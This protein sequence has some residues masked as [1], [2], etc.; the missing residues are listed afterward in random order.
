[1]ENKKSEVSYD[2]ENLID[3]ASQILLKV[4]YSRKEAELTARVLVEANLRGV[5][6]HGIARLKRYVDDVINKTTI[7]KTKPEIVFETPLSAVIDGHG[8]VGQIISLEA[9][10]LAIKKAKTSGVGM[11]A[12]R[13]SNHYG[14]AGFYAEMAA[15]EGMIGFS[16]TNSSPM[17]VPTFG[18]NM[19][20]GTNPIAYAFPVGNKYPLLIDMAT[21]VVPKGKLE[22]YDRLDKNLPLGWAT[23]ENGEVCGDPKKVLYNMKSQ[24]GGGILPLGGEGEEFSGHKGFGFGL[25]VEVLTGGLSHGG[26]SPDTYNN[27]GNISHFFQAIRLDMFG[28]KDK[29]A[30]HIKSF[31]QKIKDSEKSLGNERIYIHGEKEYE[32]REKIMKGKL[33][34]DQKTSESL[35]LLAKEYKIILKK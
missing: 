15:K 5:D 24:I 4:S 18:K 10:K 28:D 12:V 9:M 17:V 7:P 6:S 30:K 2:Y 11:V 3:F 20:L 26:F 25:L 14:I 13:N 34:L 16:S 27:Q 33:P 8:G 23:D 19:L 22:V 31:L 1:M 32:L 29:I 21:S 35:E